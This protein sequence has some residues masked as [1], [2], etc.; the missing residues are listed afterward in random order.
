MP[1]VLFMDILFLI[2]WYGGFF[3][4]GYTL[5]GKYEKS[6]IG[7]GFLGA[8]VPLSLLY[9]AFKGSPENRQQ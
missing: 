4:L 2:L 3:Y 1:I 7:W 9:F 5:A 8:I 6:K